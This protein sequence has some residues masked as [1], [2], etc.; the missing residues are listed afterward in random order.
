MS[1][2]NALALSLKIPYSGVLCVS[3]IKKSSVKV[4]NLSVMDF[5][6]T[7]TMVKNFGLVKLIF[8]HMQVYFEV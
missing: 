6:N 4:R 5:E 2:R 7:G 8:A 1:C 3:Y